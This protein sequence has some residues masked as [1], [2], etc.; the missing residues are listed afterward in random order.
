[1][2]CRNEAETLLKNGKGQP[3]MLYHNHIF[4][5]PEGKQIRV[6]IDTDAQNEADDQYAI[7]QAL[8][9]PRLDI[10]AIVAAHFGTEKSPH[11]MLDSYTEIRTILEIMNRR[12]PVF[13]IPVFCGEEKALEEDANS[14]SVGVRAII[15]E[16]R[17][18]GAPL[19]VISLGALTNCARALK[20]APDIAKRMTVVWIG[21][22]AYPAGGWEYNLKNDIQAA[23][24]VLESSV[25]LWQ[26]PQNVYQRM[27]VSIAE[28]AVRVRPQGELG[29]YLFSRLTAW[30]HTF[31][32]RR[33]PQRTGECW[34]LGDSPAV[35]VLLNEHEFHYH[36]QEAPRIKEDY[37]YQGVISG[38]QI[39]VYDRVDSR[40]ILEDLYAKLALFAAGSR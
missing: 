33:S 37:S 20:E 29:E 25:E 15:E 34:F 21:G 24:I 3:W 16:A 39:R 18:D 30:G 6:I 32:G 22:G 4:S 23:R 1:M 17:R 8:L 35:G 5:V 27:L 13:D 14:P 40:F 9:S 11:S 26:I 12:E 10:K 31:W 7:A 19:F 2:R 38:R 36:M 28:L